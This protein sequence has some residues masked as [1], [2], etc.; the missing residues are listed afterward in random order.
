MSGPN[1]P[2]DPK[3]VAALQP[4]QLAGV[5][6]DGRAAFAAATT[7]D[8]LAAA[9]TAHLGGP[10]PAAP[11]AAPGPRAPVAPPRRERGALP[12]QARADA[13]RRVNETLQALQ[14]AYDE[15]RAALE[16]ERDERVL[17][18]ERGDVT[19]PWDRAPRGGRHPLTLVQERVADVFVAM[20][21][22]IAEGPEAEAEWLNFD[23][24]NIPAHH[25]A[26]EEQDTLWL[27][28]P[29][30]GVVLRTHTSPVPLRALLKRGAPCYVAVPG[31]V[32]RSDPLDATH[33]PVFHQV[34]GLAVDEGLTMADLR[35]TLD[36]F[37]SAMF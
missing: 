37:A 14:A 29:E 24:L 1:D 32:Y 28:P 21:W 8:E 26:R 5:A 20:G 22:E 3:E 10:A 35:G 19:L 30:A 12:P 36:L 31:R 18:E 15:R 6:E 2:Y 9:H 11:P 13:G 33:S 7:L 17:V 4:E 27:D 34:E 16:R 23:A 25:S